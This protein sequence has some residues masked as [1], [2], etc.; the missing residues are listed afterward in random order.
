MK[1]LDRVKEYRKVRACDLVPHPAN[2]RTH[3]DVQASA[4]RDLLKEIGFAGAVIARELKDGRL[5]IIDGHLRVETMGKREVGVLVTDL[6]A[7]EAEKLLLTYDPLGAMATADQ[8]RLEAL[9][10][11]VRLDSQAVGAM[12]EKFAGDAA[13]QVVNQPKELVEPPAQIDKAG[14]FQRKWGTATGQLW[15]IGDHRLLCGDSTKAEDVAKLMNGERAVLFA[16][17]PPYAIGY[18]GG[19]HPQ[20][21]GNR[22]A[23]NRDKDWSGKYVEAESADVRNAEEAGVDLY[24]GF[25]GTAIRHAITRNAAWY[26]WHASRRQM[27]LESIWNEFDAFVH[28]QIIW[29]KTRAVLT[30]S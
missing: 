10:A 22:G 26:C 15:Q 1:I 14:E 20:S 25:V 3:P 12:L 30:Y 5:Q 11:S 24:R 7:E 28:Q 2:W 19:S 4:L 17:D 13:W 9:L 27:M 29:V 23:A 8:T 16:T 18:T 21:W 6:T